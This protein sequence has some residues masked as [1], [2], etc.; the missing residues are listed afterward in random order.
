MHEHGAG[1]AAGFVQRLLDA[2]AVERD[3]RIDVVS[4]CSEVGELAAEAETHR[5]HLAGALRPHPQRLHRGA[6]IGDPLVHVEALVIVEGLGE[7]GLAVAEVH[8][9][10]H[11]PEEI[12]HETDVALLGV[13]VGDRPQARV[14][15]ENLLLDEQARPAARLGHRQIAPERAATRD[16]NV[17]HR[18]CHERL[19]SL[20]NAPIDPFHS[21]SP[22]PA[23]TRRAARRRRAAVKA[24]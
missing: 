4:C 17:D 21:A 19:C 3:R 6:D 2:D 14:D 9:R 15:P 1:D 16:G 11:A 13:K 24:Y 22:R 20:C 8:A 7:V 23:A 12:G 5:C 18:T 10:L